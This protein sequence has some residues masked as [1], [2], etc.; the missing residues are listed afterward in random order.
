[1]ALHSLWFHV[2][3]ESCAHMERGT[4]NGA[5]LLAGLVTRAPTLEQ[6]VPQGLHPQQG[7]GAGEE[8]ELLPGG[9]RSSRDNV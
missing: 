1:M 7:P 6:P 2:Q 9:K 5:G 4:H 8:C 3:Q